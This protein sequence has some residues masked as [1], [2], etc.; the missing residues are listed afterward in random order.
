M[1]TEHVSIAIVIQFQYTIY[2]VYVSACACVWM[3]VK[4]W[5]TCPYGGLA[6]TIEL[7]RWN[8]ILMLLILVLSAESMGTIWMHA[9]KHTFREREKETNMIVR[10]P[11]ELKSS[12]HKL[13]TYGTL[14]LTCAT[15][16]HSA[17][18][19][20]WLTNWLTVRMPN[21]VQLHLHLYTRHT[22]I[23]KQHNFILIVYSS[24]KHVRIPN[25]NTLDYFMCGMIFE[26][27]VTSSSSSSSRRSCKRIAKLLHFYV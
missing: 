2:Y 3:Y 12:A 1:G 14:L 13:S 27:A 16:L 7:F 4:E 24:H 18:N 8:S 19:S 20:S 22:Q 5:K 17:E 26:S 15:C 21:A 9:H 23:N 11:I 25:A 6:K 10:T